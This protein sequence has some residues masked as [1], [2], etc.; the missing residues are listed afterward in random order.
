M[1]NYHP[2][3]AVSIVFLGLSMV[4]SPQLFAQS[5]NHPNHSI[6]QLI[7]LDSNLQKFTQVR[8]PMEGDPGFFIDDW[9]E[10]KNPKISYSKVSL[11]ESRPV[12][13]QA[14]VDYSTPLVKVSKYIFGNNLGH[15]TNRKMLANDDFIF[16]LKDISIPVIRFPGGNASND[17][18]WNAGSLD[19]C[20]EGTPSVIYKQGFKKTTPPKLGTNGSFRTRPEDYYELLLRTKSTGSIC[21]NYSMALYSEI[22]DEQKRVE[23]AADYAAAWVKEV[24]IKRGL[25]I[26]FWEIGNENWGKW[27]A[28]YEVKNGG[29]IDPQKYGQH[30]KLFIEKMKAVDPSIKVGVVGYQKPKT[31][32][33]VQKRWNELVLPEIIDVA[34]FYILH[35][36]Y[37]KHGAVLTPE[38]MLN[39]I[40]TTYSHIRVVNEAIEKFTDKKANH[41]PIAL[42]EFNTRSFAKISE[43]VGVSNVSHCA[44]L[45]FAHALGEII[46]QGYGMAMMWDIE[47]GFK[48][49]QDHGM[50]ASKKE[51][52]VPWLNPHP[53]FYHYFFYNQYFGDTYYESRSTKSSL[54]LHAS[55]F[56][57][58]ELGIVAVNM[59]S[60]EEILELSISNAKIGDVAGV[61]ELSSDAPSSRKVA[62]NGVVPKKNAGGPENFLKVK[63]NK[64]A[65]KNDKITLAIKPF[66]ANYILVEN[67]K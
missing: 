61:Y 17:Y 23:V 6:E 30:C 47:N 32:D 51:G 38:E 67:E 39:A 12:T 64:I 16:N 58:G 31:R 10:K 37:A 50:F 28:G 11:S 4:L 1:S 29:I 27:Q 41:L 2:I 20:P 24:N 35:D 25:N 62:V 56:S 18:F 45:F 7:E 40:D 43:N 66:S 59:S 55:S 44:G 57:S 3:Q 8:A 13:V 42:T 22:E 60:K 36:Y 52:D 19:Q 33:P 49:G 53:S 34:D 46:R 9:K 26:K 48:D 21:V 5:N 65:L 14:A 63:A 54:R 15:W